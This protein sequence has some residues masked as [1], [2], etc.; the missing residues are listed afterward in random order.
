[1]DFFLESSNL[2]SA[3]WSRW[4][5]IAFPSSQP[6]CKTQANL[7]FFSNRLTKDGDAGQTFGGSSCSEHAVYKQE[8]QAWGYKLLSARVLAQGTDSCLLEVI[9]TVHFHSNQG[10]GDF[11]KEIRTV[12][13]W[14]GKRIEGEWDSP[15]AFMILR[16]GQGT[17]RSGFCRILISGWLGHHLFWFGE[18]AGISFYLENI[19][20]ASNV[21]GVI[22]DFI[23]VGARQ[24]S[25]S[26][27]SWCLRSGRLALRW[28][29]AWL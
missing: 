27:R 21:F 6:G 11:D 24:S 23:P 16:R 12:Q 15:P 26:V 20:P 5:R 3:T 19:S 7:S 22:M 13:D 2:V 8:V 28:K 25:Y 1:M 14:K 9:I 10:L 29:Q 17:L 18:N 4:K